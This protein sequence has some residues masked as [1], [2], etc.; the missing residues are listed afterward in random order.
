MK[1]AKKSF[2]RGDSVAA[3][4]RRFVAEIIRDDFP[5][6]PVTIVDAKSA[7][8]LQF[9]RIFYQGKKTDF[10]KITAHI[11]RELAH[12]MNQRYVPELDFTYDDTLEKAERIEDLLKAI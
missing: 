8:G 12:R 1:Q 6:L 11:R 3:A 10:S 5:D 7:G 4:V 2:P 9:V